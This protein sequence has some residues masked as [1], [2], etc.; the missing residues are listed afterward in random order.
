MFKNVKRSGNGWLSYFFGTDYDTALF[1]AVQQN[2][3][4]TVGILLDEKGYFSDMTG[5][6]STYMPAEVTPVTITP[7]HLA[8]K[9]G[10][11]D[12]VDCLLQYGANS[13][14][15]AY[16]PVGRPLWTPL[17]YA[18]VYEKFEVAKLLLEQHQVSI[19]EETL[20]ILEARGCITALEFLKTYI[21]VDEQVMQKAQAMYNTIITM[22]WFESNNKSVSSSRGAVESVYFDPMTYQP[23][24]LLAAAVE[25]GEE[26]LVASSLMQSYFTR[27][28]LNAPLHDIESWDIPKELRKT[29]PE[30]VTKIESNEVIS[31]SVGH[32]VATQNTN[33]V[34]ILFIALIHG[35][36]SIA[37]ML[38]KKGADLTQ[39][40]NGIT[41][42]NLMAVMFTKPPAQ[43][44]ANLAFWDQEHHEGSEPTLKPKV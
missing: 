11:L 1:D 25:A 13:E 15:V 24:A 44:A 34:P 26:D 35:Q 7:L 33:K 19:G 16:S 4:D 31:A 18:L 10:A 37:N 12:I 14:K 5:D 36:K 27:E 17:Q 43:K 29:H 21:A 30:L 2:A 38:I 39:L 9:N 23:D 32:Y 40:V 8:A 28:Q 6:A 41:A 22:H 20:S 42:A 3:L